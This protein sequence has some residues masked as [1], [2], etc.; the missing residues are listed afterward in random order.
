MNLEGLL[1][2]TAGHNCSKRGAWSPHHC[3]NFCVWDSEVVLQQ[4]KFLKGQ[5]YRHQQKPP[6][7]KSQLLKQYRGKILVLIVH[8]EL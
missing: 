6:H 2:I 5:P 1:A 3:A 8:M 4:R 7:E